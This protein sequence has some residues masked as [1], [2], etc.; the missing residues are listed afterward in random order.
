M[1]RYLKFALL[2]LALTLLLCGLVACGTAKEPTE[3]TPPPASPTSPGA[4]THP[5]GFEQAA[6]LTGVRVY[7]YYRTGPG[8]YSEGHIRLYYNPTLKKAYLAEDDRGKLQRAGQS[9]T[10]IYAGSV[11]LFD[12][13][14][15]LSLTEGGSEY[16]YWMGE[17]TETPTRFDQRL[18]LDLGF[19]D[20]TWTVQLDAQGGTGIEA[21]LSL[22]YGVDLT[23][24]FPSP[25]KPNATFLGWKNAEGVLVTDALGIPLEGYQYLTVDAFE[26]TVL[27]E[28]SNSFESD[29]EA[30]VLTAAYSV[31]KIPVTVVDEQGN[32]TVFEFDAGSLV[33]ERDF[34]DTRVHGYSLS[35]TGGTSFGAFTLTAPTTVYKFA[36]R[37]HVRIHVGDLR[38]ETLSLLKSTDSSSWTYLKVNLADDEGYT[39]GGWYSD[40]AYQHAVDPYVQYVTALTDYYV[41][42]IPVTP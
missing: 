31:Q 41:K 7:V 28:A 26:R 21:R 33:T 22:P 30:V 37:K 16:E 4:P 3:D 5:D 11:C 40:A 32:S 42:L 13:N 39:F 20:D 15:N 8:S 18:E 36:I 25:V 9:F 12:A 10:G 38:V 23:G 27:L 17:M 1:K 6:E 14:L 29:M 34:G 35:A 24:Q 2:L 19:T